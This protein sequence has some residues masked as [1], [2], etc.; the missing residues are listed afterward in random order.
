M[1]RKAL[2][3][4]P[5]DVFGRWTIVREGERTAKR[6][7][8]FW[9]QC[10]CGSP[11]KLV[12]LSH[13][14][15]GNPQSCSCLR[16]EEAAKRQ[17]THGRSDTLIHSIWRSMRARCNNPNNKKYESYGGRGITVCARWDSF[18]NF[19]ADMGKCPGKGYSIDRI[20]NNKS[21]FPEN[22]DWRTQKEQCRNQRTNSLLTYQGKTQCIA[23]WAEQLGL[24]Y[25][26]LRSRLTKLKWPIERA[27]TTPTR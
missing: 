16:K 10:E 23:A 13:I 15:S 18:E 5:G 19:A 14:K 24:N 9:C 12:R 20:D 11:E 7:R 8:R 26:T 6:E 2:A 1:K 27:L 22:C 4:N 25:G 17:T 21:Y 3:L